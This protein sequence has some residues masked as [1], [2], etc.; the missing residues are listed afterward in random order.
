MVAAVLALG[1]VSWLSMALP[2]LAVDMDISFLRLAEVH[3]SCVLLGLVFGTMALG[4]G[5]ATGSRG[6]SLGVASALAVAA[7]FVNALA[8]LVESLES[9]QKLSPFYLYI[10]G[11][12]LSNGLEPAHAGALFGLVAAFAAL[13]I[14]LFERR[15]LS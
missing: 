13:G 11:D 1:A 14:L 9:A 8:P 15:D 4:L 7:Y 3:I 5:C 12:P 2:A 6:L 10:G